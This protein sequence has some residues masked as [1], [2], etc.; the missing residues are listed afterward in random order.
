[1]ETYKI[2]IR[3]VDQLDTICVSHRYPVVAKN[4]L[5][6]QQTWNPDK[7]SLL[8]DLNFPIQSVLWWCVY[9]LE[10]GQK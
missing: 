7:P 2:V 9:K 8:T 5:C 4:I 10:E 6:V 1:M 3:T